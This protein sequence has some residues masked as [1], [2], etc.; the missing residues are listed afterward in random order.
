MSTPEEFEVVDA[1]KIEFVK[2]GRK[3]EADPKLIEALRGL[4]K[5]KTLAVKKMTLD[6]Q[7]DTYGK[8]KARISS[9][10]RTACRLANLATFSITWDRN[11]TPY[12]TA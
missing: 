11:G 10:I 7:A 4:G 9:Q 5:G 1:S 2:R 6:P 8:D 3:A 12:V